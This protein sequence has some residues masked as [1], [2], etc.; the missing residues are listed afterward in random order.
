MKK[1]TFLM[2]I[3]FLILISS[4]FANSKKI[5]FR[6][7]QESFSY[8]SEYLLWKGKIWTRENHARN[9]DS[10]W[11]LFDGKGVPHGENAKSFKKGDYIVSFAQEATM[12]VAVSNRQRIYLWQPTIK[13]DTT[14]EEEHGAPFADSVYLPAHKDWT[15]SLSLT[16]A[17]YKRLTPMHDIVSYYEDPI[18][19]KIEFGFTAT[20]Y[21][22]DPDG[23]KIRYWDTGLPA[24]FDRAF[25][26]PERGQFKAEKLAAAGSTL[27]VIDKSGR[28][29]TRMYDYEINTGCPGLR[30]TYDKEWAK[31]F[32]TKGKE[33][34]TL[35]DGIRTLPL[36]SWV[37]HANIPLIG[38]ASI[39]SKIS[40]ILTGKGNAARQLRVQGT[41]EKGKFG[42]Y[43]KKLNDKKWKFKI[44][45][46]IFKKNI[47]LD[48]N[49]KVKLGRKLDKTYTGSLLQNGK[50]PLKIELVDFY[51]FNDRATLR[52]YYPPKKHFDMTLYTVDSWAATVNRKFDPWMVGNINGVPKN[53]QGTLEIPKSILNSKHPKVK[54]II[55]TYFRRFHLATFAFD[56][57][58]DDM[59]VSLQ[60]RRFS[61]DSYDGYLD[62]G[63]KTPISAELT[64]INPLLA[65]EE[66]LHG[67]SFMATKPSLIIDDPEFLTSKDVRR[68]KQ[69]ITA[70][71]KMIESLRKL[72]AAE[73]DRYLKNGA[74]NSFA[75]AAWNILHPLGELTGFPMFDT[76]SG[77]LFT[78][79]GQFLSI[80]ASMNL[81]K[82]FSNDKDYEFALKLIEERIQI[83]DKTLERID[84]H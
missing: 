21:T 12:L 4:A 37:P 53:L 13:V 48:I 56:I 30:W 33:V 78:T 70:N 49:S 63:Y 19:N 68:V 65:P 23:Q 16:K 83:Y 75:Y 50:S 64:N 5:Y 62:Y 66:L 44:T 77:N 52:V 54:K 57:S 82:W 42:Y 40:I 8:E 14:W 45:D 10:K 43:Y 58:A 25:P 27:M 2:L 39:T 28:I 22:L 41:N 20:V 47:S 72:R 76:L 59:K 71:E 67:Y 84:S 3:T 1:S 69:A 81:S 24:S 35:F 29:F 32:K 36:E 9:K 6:T 61:R 38:K 15:F 31:T 74:F 18:G 26:T 73:R 11:E 17:D 46:E 80:Q 55:D 51:Y 7:T 60:S 34:K 79:G